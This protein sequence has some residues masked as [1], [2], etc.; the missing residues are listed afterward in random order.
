[1]SDFA[2]GLFGIVLVIAYIVFII[3]IVSLI[4]GTL[5]STL[6]PLLGIFILIVIFSGEN[7]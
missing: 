1:M 5:V 6:G 7:G 4:G 3:W 2:W